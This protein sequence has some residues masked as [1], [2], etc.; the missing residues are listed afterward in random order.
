ML[1]PVSIF[2]KLT[3]DQLL[4]D[5]SGQHVGPETSV[6]NCHHTLRI[7]LR[8]AKIS[9]PKSDILKK[10]SGMSANVAQLHVS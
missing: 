6:R 1:F 2:M 4:T 8:R 9:K 5:I 10:W 7:Y 3:T